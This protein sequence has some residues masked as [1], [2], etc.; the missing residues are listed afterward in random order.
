MFGGFGGAL[1]NLTGKAEEALEKTK[2]DIEGL[3]TEKKQKATELLEQ[4]AK[5][6]GEALLLGK[7][8]LEKTAVGVATDAKKTA[9]DGFDKEVADAEKK[10]D[11]AVKEQIIEDKASAPTAP[12]DNAKDAIAGALGGIGALGALGNVDQEIN[13]AVDGAVKEV[14]HVVD[15]KMKEADEFVDHKR[16]DVVK[17][18]Q[19]N[20]ANVSHSAGEQVGSVLGKAKGLL[21]F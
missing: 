9:I 2:K 10:V 12:G 17:Q 6:T 13:K 16:D 4:Q 15:E 3:A 21:K 19:E 20:V 1:K 8:E 5:K 11:D 14:S 18:V 7:S